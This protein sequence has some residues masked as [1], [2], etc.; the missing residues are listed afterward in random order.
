MK[1]QTFTLIE[2]LVVIAIIAILAAMLLPALNKARERARKIQ[3]ANNMKTLGTSFAMYIN[4]NSGRFPVYRSGP[5]RWYSGLEPGANAYFMGT[6]TG[7]KVMDKYK[8]GNIL[9]CPTNRPVYDLSYFPW[10]SKTRLDYGINRDLVGYTTTRYNV[11]K[12]RKPSQIAT[13][14]EGGD[15]INDPPNGFRAYLMSWGTH[16]FYKMMNWICHNNTANYGFV[17]GHVQSTKYSSRI[18]E[19]WFRPDLQ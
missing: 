8:E 19:P 4:D 6:Y 16:S 10:G 11:S 2:L 9:D 3:C 1:K 12:I 18:V 14:G 15:I 7:Y 13:F 17:D 5:D